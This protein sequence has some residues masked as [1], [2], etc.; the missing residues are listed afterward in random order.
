MNH[1]EN[2]TRGAA[3]AIGKDVTNWEWVWRANQLAYQLV[4]DAGDSFAP[5]TDPATAYM[6]ED[7]L[8]MNVRYV[9]TEVSAEVSAE[10]VREAYS[11]QVAG[12]LCGGATF[13]AVAGYPSTLTAR[14][15]AVTQFAALSAIMED[16][17]DE[18]ALQAAFFADAPLG[19]VQHGDAQCG[20]MH[21]G[22]TQYGEVTHVPA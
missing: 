18:T 15:Y 21:N 2:I 5:L 4:S 22:E 19:E 14:M 13:T 8:R 9:C 7:A 17:G 11:I 1:L 20:E 6:L 16:D 3:K 12:E 10:G